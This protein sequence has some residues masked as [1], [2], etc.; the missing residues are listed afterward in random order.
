MR[1]FYYMLYKVGIFCYALLLSHSTHTHTLTHA[2]T[3][4]V[5]E[6]H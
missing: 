1:N 3:Q 4:C 2:Y 5:L 6:V